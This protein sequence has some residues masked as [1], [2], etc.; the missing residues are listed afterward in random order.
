[1]AR[2]TVGFVLTLLTCAAPALARQVAPPELDRAQRE[3]LQAVVVAVD[4]AVSAPATP[5]EEWQTH[6]LRTSDGAHY[7]A[8]SVTPASANAASGRT[9][10]YVRLATR[11]ES[12]AVAATE[13]SAV[14]E[15][16][17]GMRSDPLVAQK[18]RGVVFGEMPTFGAAAVASRGIGQQAADLKVL[19]LQQ[20]RERQR[21]ETEDRQRK[22]SLEGMGSRAAG[23]L[24]PFEDFSVGTPPDAAPGQAAIVRRS[25]TAGPGDYDV[26]VA[27]AAPAARGQRPIV[28]VKKQRLQ[29]PP[30]STAD[31]AL[32][33]V[34]V[35]DDLTTRAVPVPPEQQTSHPYALGSME[36]VPARAAAFTNDQRLTI[37]LQVFN[38][39]G[40]PGGKP[41]VA[42]GFQL[43]RVLPTGEQSMGL[44]NPQ[45]YSESTLP[46]D[47]DINKGHPLFVAMGAPLRTLPRGE[48]RLMI[49]A[50]DRV[51]QRAARATTSFR[52]VATPQ[53]L[54]STAQT[55]RPFERD[56]VLK[57]A[58]LQFAAMRLRPSQPSSAMASAL[59][60]ARDA[61]Y[62]ELLRDDAVVEQEKSARAALKGIG[63]YALGDAR[64]ACATLQRSHGDGR[65]PATLLFVGACRALERNDKDAVAAWSDALAGE[66]PAD[67]VVPLLI[68]AHVRLGEH[69]RA[70][71][72][73]RGLLVGDVPP[74]PIAAGM[75]AA[76]IAGGQVDDAVRLITRH[77]AANPDD[78][79]ARYALLH[80]LFA[81][82][83]R[84]QGVGSTRDG[85]EQFRTA[86]TAYIDA[87]GRHAAVVTEWLGVLP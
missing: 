81:G 11:P 20:E 19:A 16:L 41:D 69:A 26:F 9:V 55:V 29:L 3:L 38:A 25:L 82:H 79:D 21:R 68:D 46:A 59:D 31:L 6:V 65:Q 73:A 4:E 17:K 71:Q 78:Q 23:T 32:S 40:N 62:L 52:V 15:W 8:F 1:M 50:T 75:A 76:L 33:S 85:Q 43:F 14:M 27:W 47:F 22:A 2:R 80:A 53:T 24:F 10:T 87:K 5:A 77:L 28:H 12:P 61:R 57:P 74:R 84:G 35:A 83:V 45:F 48:Y 67:V 49:E 39:R 13:R 42:V 56:D 54:L 72:L 64:I 51:V 60:A 44:L 66:A 34:I 7:V 36:I 37:V 18:Q 86:A 30:A 70:L 63:L 58:A